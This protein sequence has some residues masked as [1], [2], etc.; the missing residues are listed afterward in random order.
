MP[1]VYSHREKCGFV[2]PV[3]EVAKPQF[4]LTCSGCRRN[5]QLVEIPEKGRP[6]IL[7]C[8]FCYHRM[9]VFGFGNPTGAFTAPI[10]NQISE[11]LDYMGWKKM[12][13]AIY[14]FCTDNE[15][16]SECFSFRLV[17]VVENHYPED[18]RI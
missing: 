4:K 15:Y 17:D 16:I 9:I 5:T 12:R 3:P 7:Q 13:E 1:T 8:S 2:R 14:S 10:T 11:H 6:H 18:K